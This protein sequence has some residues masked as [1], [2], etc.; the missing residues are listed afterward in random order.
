MPTYEYRCPSGHVFERFYPRVTDRRRLPCPQ[1]GKRAERQISAG[2]GVVFK[3]SGFYAT[4]YQRAGAKAEQAEKAETETKS[5]E[6]KP[7]EKPSSK[8]SKK[9][10]GSDS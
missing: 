5:A 3:G 8:S 10:R 4:D 1:C 9:D 7:A 2:A 6:S